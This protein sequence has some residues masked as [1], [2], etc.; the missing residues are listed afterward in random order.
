MLFWWFKFSHR[1]VIDELASLCVDVIETVGTCDITI[2][3]E[4]SEDPVGVS[5]VESSDNLVDVV[6]S[7]SSV[8]SY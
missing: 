2:G 8:S 4:S 3:F 1:F 5:D 6:D 7:P